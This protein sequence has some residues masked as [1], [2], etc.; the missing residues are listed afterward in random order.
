MKIPVFFLCTAVSLTVVAAEVTPYLPPADAV[1]HVLLDHPSVQAA[2]SQLRA[3]E[4]HRDRLEAGPYEWNLRLGGQQ[5]RVT[6]LGSTNQRFNEWNLALDRPLRLPDKA[7][8]DRVLGENGI[9]LAK[10]ARSNILHESKRSLLKSWF[11]WLKETAAARQWAAQVVILEQQ[12]AAVKRRQMLG[13]APRIESVQIEAALAQARAQQAQADLRARSA[14]EDL[15]RRYPGLPLIEPTQ[16]GEPPA[17]TGTVDEWISAQLEN[18]RELALARI[19]SQRGR[20]LASRSSQDRLPDPSIGLQFSRERGGEENVIGAYINIP[21][22][23]GAR[24]ASAEAAQAEAEAAD[25]RAATVE[26]LVAAEAAAQFYAAQ[27]SYT[28]WQAV[29]SAADQLRTAADMAAR[30]YELGEGSLNDLLTARRQA[31]EAA[32]AA[33]LSK[34]DALEAYYRLLL[35][36]NRLWNF[37]HP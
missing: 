8:T 16:E 15:R 11:A 21:L 7:S 14:G 29:Q 32:L 28:A 27:A 33:R 24:H 4:A 30:A 20:L 18:N 19:E 31:N 13:D 25:R 1:A 35:D 9:A 2:N 36:T 3:A 37:D 6:P 5:R 10:M 17:L 12:A 23:G 22:S 26:Q 34:L